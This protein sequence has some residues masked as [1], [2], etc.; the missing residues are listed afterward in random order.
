MRKALT[1]A[2]VIGS[3]FL[4]TFG[5]SPSFGK[6]K[7]TSSQISMINLLTSRVSDAQKDVNKAQADVNKAQLASAQKQQEV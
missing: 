3:A 1:K 2:V 4:L 5:S 7:C 6:A